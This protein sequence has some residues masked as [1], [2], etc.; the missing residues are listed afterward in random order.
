MHHERKT[1][2]TKACGDAVS[3]NDKTRV[4]ISVLQTFVSI[5]SFCVHEG[6]VDDASKQKHGKPK[7]CYAHIAKS[8]FGGGGRGH[9]QQSNKAT[10]TQ[11]YSNTVT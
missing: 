11:Q 2:Q 10:P 6:L 5:Q 9:S 1:E 4:K 3:Q 8:I 7:A